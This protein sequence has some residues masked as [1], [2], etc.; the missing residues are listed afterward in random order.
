M[1]EPC[2]VAAE[3]ARGDVIED[4]RRL[5]ESGLHT[6]VE[7]GRRQKWDAWDGSC[8]GVANLPLADSSYGPC[9]DGVRVGAVFHGLTAMASLKAYTDDKSQLLCGV[10]HGLTAMASLK[11]KFC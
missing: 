4:G 10:F 1:T 3:T 11:D 5:L 7:G 6:G 8:G 9:R 2:Y